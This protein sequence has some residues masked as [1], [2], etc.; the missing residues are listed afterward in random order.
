[1]S[2][3]LLETRCGV[4]RALDLSTARRCLELMRQRFQVGST[5]HH[6][7]EVFQR[8]FFLGVVAIDG[9]AAQDHEVVPHRIRVVG[10]V[11]DE[12]HTDAPLLGLEDVLEH[13][14][15]LLDTLRGRLQEFFAI[16][17]VVIGGTLLT[18]GY[19]SAI[20]AFFGALIFAMV[21][22]GIIITGVDGDWFQVFVGAVLIVAVIF[23][24]FVRERAA[25]R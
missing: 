1:M 14:S 23:N 17:A 8:H 6:L 4:L 9:A 7:D 19:G 3:R 18:G 12:D 20:G 24:N 10:V 11:G 25:K 21:Q 16:I 13:H 15:G 2:T 22:Q 5:G